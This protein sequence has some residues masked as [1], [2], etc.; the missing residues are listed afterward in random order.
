M[1]GERIKEKEEI[2]KNSLIPRI[3]EIG[4][5]RKDAKEREGLNSHR[6]TVHNF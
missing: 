3:K 5:D 2:E 4:T 1:K 6:I